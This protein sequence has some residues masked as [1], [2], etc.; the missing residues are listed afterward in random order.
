MH[1]AQC[2]GGAFF[3]LYIRA[4]TAGIATSAFA[5]SDWRHSLNAVRLWI[6]NYNFNL[7]KKKN[8]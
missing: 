7:S 2:L 3:C 4:R 8:A 5:N 6:L 1:F